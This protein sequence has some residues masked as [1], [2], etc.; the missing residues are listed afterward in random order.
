[1][2]GCK[3][4]GLPFSI[5][6][7]RSWR[8]THFRLRAIGA[9][10][11]RGLAAP[12]AAI[13]LFLVYLQAVTGILPLTRDPLARL[14]G[15]GMADAAQEVA[16]LAQKTGA[17]AVLTSDYETTAWMRLI[18]PELAIVAIDRPE[19]YLDAPEISLASGP[20]LYL[21]DQGREKD[22]ALT[23]NF[24]SVIA[25]AEVA[26]MRGTQVVARYPVWLLQTPK[27]PVAGKLP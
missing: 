5:P 21:A 7:W 15:V 10:F 23:G 3:A 24:G 4:I 26:R 27:S 16:G 8:R 2:T 17:K 19:R 1:M 11:V 14:L 9:E 20:L 22:T 25:L 13:L 6:C 12:V 18:A